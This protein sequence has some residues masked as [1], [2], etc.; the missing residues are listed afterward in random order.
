MGDPHSIV[1]IG[2]GNDARS[3]DG[4][5]VGVARKIEQLNLPGVRVVTGIADGTD[6]IHA[7]Q[8]AD[9]AIVVDSAIT[10]N[11]PGTVYRFE[12]GIDTI[13]AEMFHALSTHAFTVTDTIELARTLNLLPPLL[14]VYGIEASCFDPG[15][16]LSLDVAAGVR[17]AVDRIRRDITSLTQQKSSPSGEL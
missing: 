5:G 6:L 12:N 10:G 16:G 13:P 7:W 2:V 9:M 11:P 4:A 15:G 17:N 1:I 3:D 14:I 8:T